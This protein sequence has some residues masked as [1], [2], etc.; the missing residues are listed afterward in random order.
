[1]S[2]VSSHESLGI[3]EVLGSGSG[4]IRRRDA[5][6]TPSNDDIYVGGRVVTKFGLRTGDELSGDIGN[7]PRNGKSPPLTHLRLVNGRPPEEAKTRP[8]FNRLS[9]LHPDE[10]LRL[11]CGRTIRG[12][13]ELREPEGSLG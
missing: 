9:A 12:Q 6:Y 4:F 7:R 11:E 2:D 13:P 3:L 1:M 5:G 8:E 10:Q